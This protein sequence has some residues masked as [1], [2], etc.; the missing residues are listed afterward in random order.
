MEEKGGIALGLSSSLFFSFLFF[1]FS[2]SHVPQV[3]P[4][5]YKREGWAPNLGKIS[6]TQKHFNST[7]HT[8]ETRDLVALSPICNPYC[9]LQSR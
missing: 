6:N 8:P 4:L 3:L 5:V 2:L 1:S 7:S 9:K